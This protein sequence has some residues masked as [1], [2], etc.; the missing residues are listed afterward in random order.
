MNSQPSQILKNLAVVAFILAMQSVLGTAQEILA[1]PPPEAGPAMPPAPGIDSPGQQET[2]FLSD[3]LTA[4][5][6]ALQYGVAKLN[7]RFTYQFSYGN[8]L[9]PG[10]GGDAENSVI[11]RITPGAT[12]YFG[13]KWALD[14]APT[15]SYYSSDEFT[16]TVEHSVLFSGGTTYEDWAFGFSQSYRKSDSP[17]VETGGQTVD[18]TFNTSLSALHQL[19]SKLAMQLGL[20]QNLRFSEDYID[21]FQWS[22][23]NWLDYSIS[24]KLSAGVGGGGGYVDVSE[25]FDSVYE[26]LMGRVTWRPGEKLSLT[27][28]GGADFRQ[29]LNADLSTLVNPVYGLTGSY[30]LFENTTLLLSGSRQVSASY[31]EN[32]VNENTRISGG[33]RQRLFEKLVLSLSGGYRQSRYIQVVEGFDLG[34]EDNGYFFSSRLSTTILKKATVGIFYYWSQNNSDTQGYSYDSFQ[35]GFDISYRF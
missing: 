1:P 12:I 14:Y 6:S 19:N 33:V 28:N 2:G 31:F 9:Q 22:T 16:D 13:K 7:P 26:Q 4:G 23:M 3:V 5:E 30:D 18:D 21:V 20:S 25:G 15:I 11:H 10:R 8:Q 27:A 32:Q 34:R 29:F 24:P 35:V 17:R